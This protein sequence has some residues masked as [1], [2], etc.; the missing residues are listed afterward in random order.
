MSDN[1]NNSNLPDYEQYEYVDELDYRV[2]FG[3]RFLAWI[4]DVVLFSMLLLAV[5]SISGIIGV[6]IDSFSAAFN[7]GMGSSLDPNTIAEME[8]LGY[9]ITMYSTVIGI[10]YFSLEV[11]YGA[12]LGKMMLGLRIANAN[13]TWADTKTLLTRTAIKNISTTVNILFLITTISLISTLGS[14]LGII[15]FIGCFVALSEKKQALHDLI[16]GTAVFHK[17]EIMTEEEAEKVRNI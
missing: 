10:L 3:K 13:R 5:L 17:A 15:V 7:S 11:I 1:L 6:Y 12:T 4:I 9:E 14:I 8:A 2:G 16:A